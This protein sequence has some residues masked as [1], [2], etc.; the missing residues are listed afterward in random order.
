MI[1]NSVT[2]EQIDKL[3]D[4]ADTQEATFWGKEHIVSYKLKN[5][6]TILGRAACV[7][8]ANFDLEVGRKLARKQV[9][10]QLWGFEGYLLQQK[11]FEQN[12]NDK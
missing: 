9:I 3:L 5:G 7:D 8:P 6:F 10:D 2:I 11:L 12:A 1:K 4:E